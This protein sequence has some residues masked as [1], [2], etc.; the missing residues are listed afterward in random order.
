VIE[1]AI[2]MTMAVAIGTHPMIGVP[3]AVVGTIP[4]GRRFGGGPYAGLGIGEVVTP[5]GKTFRGLL[6]SEPKASPVRSDDAAAIEAF[7]SGHAAPSSNPLVGYLSD[8]AII[9]VCIKEGD[10][11]STN[12]KP[13]SFGEPVT[14][15]TP[16][17]LENGHV[18]VEWLYG[19]ALYYVSDITLKNHKIAV[20]KTQPAWMPIMLSKA[21]D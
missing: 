10:P 3:P 15:N 14:A 21:P 20:V 9:A 19:T 7:I 8:D 18:R 17:R 6:P 16:Y 1:F 12:T 13:T 4:D 11:C 5:D 2:V